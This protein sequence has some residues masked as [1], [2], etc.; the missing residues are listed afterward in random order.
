[1]EL[2]TIV[3]DWSGIVICLL[4]LVH[5]IL[6]WKWIVHMTML[7]FKKKKPT[8]HPQ[9]AI[10]VEKSSPVTEMPAMILEQHSK[11]STMME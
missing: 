8:V 5:L 11:K 4:V 9:T 3:H 10:I 1:M 7:S 2:F 6:H